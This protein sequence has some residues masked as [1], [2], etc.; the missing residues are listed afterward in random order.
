M[1]A[2]RAIQWLYDVAQR[3][4]LA[5]DG[6][7]SHRR[8]TLESQVWSRPLAQCHTHRKKG[9]ILSGRN[10][11]ECFSCKYS[12]AEYV[13]ECI[14][15]S[16]AENVTESRELCSDFSLVESK[17]FNC[18][19]SSTDNVAT[20]NEISCAF[21][22]AESSTSNVQPKTIDSAMALIIPKLLPN[23]IVSVCYLQLGRRGDG[24]YS[25]DPLAFVNLICRKYIR[26]M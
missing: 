26:P 22:L 1:A 12:S 20:I 5:V 4:K 2:I 9:N 3:A 16:L 14:T 7:T 18:S 17:R 13:V 23:L 21:H 8:H 11:S 6:S 19:I 25:A 15:F 10:V 24:S